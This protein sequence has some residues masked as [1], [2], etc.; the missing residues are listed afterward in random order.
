MA[1][2]GSFSCSQELSTSPYPEPDQ[3][4]PYHHPVTL[5]SILKLSNNLHLGL[6]S[7]RFPSCFPAIIL[8]IYISLLPIRATCPAYLIL[9]DLIILILCG[10]EYKLWSLVM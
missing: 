5:R 10:K 7:G 6:P 1:P 8:Y 9:T 3:S 2:E 4:S